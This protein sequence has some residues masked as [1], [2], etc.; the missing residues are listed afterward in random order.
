MER[1]RSHKQHKTIGT[2]TKQPWKCAF[3][4]IYAWGQLQHW[5]NTQTVFLFC[6]WYI[7]SH[8]KSFT[9]W[10]IKRKGNKSSGVILKTILHNISQINKQYKNYS[11]NKTRMRSVAPAEHTWE[12][13]VISNKEFFSCCVM[14]EGRLLWNLALQ[15]QFGR[16]HRQMIKL[17]ILY[18]QQASVA[19]LVYIHNLFCGIYTHTETKQLAVFTLFLLQI[20]LLLLSW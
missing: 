17:L 10:G 11:C 16:Q 13:I 20:V 6:F 12:K 8:W 18:P 4:L 7:G 9:H 15:S 2:F 5:V 14:Q 19:Y 1:K 3:F